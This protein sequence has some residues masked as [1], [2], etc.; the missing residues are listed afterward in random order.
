MFRIWKKSTAWGCKI[1]HRPNISLTNTQQQ[2]QH[3][4]GF[5]QEIGK[6]VEAAPDQEEA[7]IKA[8]ESQSHPA[9]HLGWQAPY[10]SGLE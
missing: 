7:R 10:S 8:Q 4:I 3:D 6:G 1:M 2:Q 9:H 5:V